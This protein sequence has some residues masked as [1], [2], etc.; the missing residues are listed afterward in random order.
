MTRAG[1]RDRGARFTSPPWQRALAVPGAQARRAGPRL[2][3]VGVEVPADVVEAAA[4]GAAE[5][6]ADLLELRG[7]EPGAESAEALA[8][9][10]SQLGGE[11]V[12]LEQRHVVDPA[13]ERLGRLDLD[14]AVALEPGRG[15]DQLADDD[16][17]LQ[18]RKAVDLA[19]ERGV[20]E[21]LGGLLERGR[22]EERVGRQRGLG[23]AEDDL[24]ERRRLA[25]GGLGLA[26]H[27]PQLVPV[28]EL[29]QQIAS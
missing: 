12:A 11:L 5:P 7:V 2:L 20:G 14:R 26:V 25:A 24:L 8:V 23:D 22:R 28:D 6:G 13:R 15:R 16:V 4:G 21:H 3:L 27:A 18:A 1:P 29:P 10:Q 19:L 9:V 17:L